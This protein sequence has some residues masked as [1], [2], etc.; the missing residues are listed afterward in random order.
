MSSHTKT[1]VEQTKLASKQAF[2]EILSVFGRYDPVS[3]ACNGL[4]GRVYLRQKPSDYFKLK[5]PIG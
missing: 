4:H 3:A 2:V 5:D 1:A